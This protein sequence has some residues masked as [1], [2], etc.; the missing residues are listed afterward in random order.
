MVL[1]SSVSGPAETK[2]SKD[3]VYTKNR[4]VFRSQQVGIWSQL[5]YHQEE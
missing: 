5:V 2:N 1:S 4:L 3:T